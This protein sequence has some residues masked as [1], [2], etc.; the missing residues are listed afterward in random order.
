MPIGT[1]VLALATA[2]TA[3]VV[4]LGGASAT[5]GSLAADAGEPSGAGTSRGWQ[6]PLSPRPAV[7][8]AFDRPEHRWSPGH[9]GV[10]LEATAGQAVLSPGA[11]RVTYTGLLAG[12]GVV[13][14]THAGGLRST[15]EPVTG[16]PPVGTLVAGGAAIGRVAPAAGH[17][18]PRACLHWGVLRGHDYL[19]PLSL[20]MPRPIRLLPLRP[21]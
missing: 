20:L 2:L 11:G 15:F 13:V 7:A 5:V 14:V 19:D 4:A 10:D 18:A 6:W 21:L 3:T 9:R 16:P 1:A 12:R 8:R 17:C